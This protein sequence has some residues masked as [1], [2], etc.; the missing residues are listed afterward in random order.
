MMVDVWKD[1]NGRLNGRDDPHLDKDLTIDSARFRFK[2]A[3]TMEPGGQGISEESSLTR[4][5]GISSGSLEKSIILA[6]V[7][8]GSRPAGTG[9]GSC[10]A[11]AISGIAEAGRT[12]GGRGGGDDMDSIRRAARVNGWRARYRDLFRISI[13]ERLLKDFAIIFHLE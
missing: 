2:G 12:G 9:A 7:E 13:S 1:R 4:S 11:V 5:Q 6:I 3:Q 8:S 10:P